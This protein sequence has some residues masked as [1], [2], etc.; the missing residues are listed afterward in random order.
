MFSLQWATEDKG[1]SSRTIHHYEMNNFKIGDGTSELKF[2]L[3]Y[4]NYF[5]ITGFKV[6]LLIMMKTIDERQLVS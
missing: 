1:S 3:R 5:N 2:E 4:N 6:N